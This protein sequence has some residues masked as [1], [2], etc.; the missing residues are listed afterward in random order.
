MVDGDGDRNFCFRQFQKSV[1]K[2]A[3]IFVHWSGQLLE[4]SAVA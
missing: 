4:E 2:S 3:S 1:Q